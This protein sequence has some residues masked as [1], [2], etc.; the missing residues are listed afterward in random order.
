MSVNVSETFWDD[1]WDGFEH[2]HQN[3][4]QL[5]TKRQK[6]FLFLTVFRLTQTDAYRYKYVHYDNI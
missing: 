6:N 3:F 5:S 1:G 2:K 4:I